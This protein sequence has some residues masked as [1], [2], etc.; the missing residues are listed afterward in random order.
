ME[1][2][3]SRPQPLSSLHRQIAI[4][5]A[6]GRTAVRMFLT[7]CVLSLV[8]GLQAGITLLRRHPGTVAEMTRKA[9]VR[10]QYPEQN[11]AEAR[12]PR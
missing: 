1:G 7:Q 6:V 3:P 5:D 2:W 12:P 9:F 8:P 4:R 10:G 11:R